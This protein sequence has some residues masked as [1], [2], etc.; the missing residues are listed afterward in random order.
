MEPDQADPDLATFGF[1]L[2]VTNS[3]WGSD[4]PVELYF[5]QFE[6]EEHFEVEGSRPPNWGAPSAF[7]QPPLEAPCNLRREDSLHVAGDEARHL[8]ACVVA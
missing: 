1:V 7:D 2:G 8:G 6:N 4:H 5:D 3:G